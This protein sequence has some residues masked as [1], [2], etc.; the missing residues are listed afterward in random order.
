MAWGESDVSHIENVIKHIEWLLNCPSFGL[1]PTEG[2]LLM[3]IKNMSVFLKSLSF[4]IKI[5]ESINML[6]F[7]MHLPVEWV[8]KT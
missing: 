7:V 6:L 2:S 8:I 1:P 4:D 5:E 3:I